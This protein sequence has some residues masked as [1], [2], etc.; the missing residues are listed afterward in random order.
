MNV[1]YSKQR[2]AKSCGTTAV[3]N[4]LKW[5]DGKV[6][7]TEMYRGIAKKC[8]QNEK[9]CHY[10]N[11]LEACRSLGFKAFVRKYPSI[12]FIRNQLLKQKSIIMLYSHPKDEN[13]KNKHF[14][15]IPEYIENFMIVNGYDYENIQDKEQTI[16]F[17]DN[18]RFN[19]TIS[20]KQRFAIIVLSN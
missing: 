20:K 9:G 16:M 6:S 13:T 2:H 4:A 18:K 10:L 12:D 11:I 17:Y 19:S 15:F 14:I 5:R 7:Y 1:R 3:L 8:K